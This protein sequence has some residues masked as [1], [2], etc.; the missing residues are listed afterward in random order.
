MLD[1]AQS[2]VAVGAAIAANAA[3]RAVGAIVGLLCVLVLASTSILFFTMAGYRALE[4]AIGA[5]QAPLIVGGVYFVA[6]LIALVAVQA[7][8]S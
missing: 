1:L 2:L 4:Q 7:R 8:K 5:I 6:A 3:R